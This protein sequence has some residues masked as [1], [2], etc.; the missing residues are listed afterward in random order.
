MEDRDEVAI[1]AGSGIRK[2]WPV[3]RLAIPGKTAPYQQGQATEAAPVVSYRLMFIDRSAL[4]QFS[5]LI[6]LMRPED[7]IPQRGA[8]PIP[9]VVIA[10]MMPHVILLQP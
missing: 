2:Q 9:R 4:H 7:V 8:N 3:W 5:L 10:V 1:A 6:L